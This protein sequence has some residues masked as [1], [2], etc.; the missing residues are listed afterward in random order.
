[1]S[2]SFVKPL[3]WAGAVAAVVGLCAAFAGCTTETTTTSNNGTA[4]AAPDRATPREGG[5]PSEEDAGQTPTEEECLA[6]CEETHAAG[7]AKDRAIDQC[8]ETSCKGPCVDGN[9]GFDAG[10]ADAGDGG[11]QCGNPVDT[12]DVACDT[13]TSTHCCG[14]WDGCF[15]DPGCTDLNTCRNECLGL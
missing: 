1:M 3:L 9:G 5:G 13:C 8:W 15:N 4:D 10:A 6:K 11:L 7:L 12:G 2:S 14:V